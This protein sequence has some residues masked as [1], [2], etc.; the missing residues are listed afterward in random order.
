MLFHCI[1]WPL[2]GAAAG[3][4]GR[5]LSADS[6]GGGRSS[7]SGGPVGLGVCCVL[8]FG[9][10]LSITHIVVGP[11]LAVLILIS[12]SPSVLTIKKT[13]KKEGFI[14]YKI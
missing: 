5:H 11:A 14:T 2:P 6:A 13:L 10:G 1:N 8:C 12:R 3:E 4:A 7:A 9:L